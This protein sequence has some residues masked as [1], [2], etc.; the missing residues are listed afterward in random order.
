MRSLRILM[1]TTFY[2][3]YSFGGDAVGV[4][5][6]ARALAARGHRVAV[7]HDEDAYLN[8]GGRPPPAEAAAADDGVARIGLKARAGMVS[9]L[10]VQ[11]TGRPVL[12]AGRLREIV[13]A[14]PWDILWYNNMSL[15]GGP[16][17][18][19]YGDGLRVYEAHEHWLVC[20]THVLWR[21]GRELC[22]ARHCLSCVLSYRRPPQLWRATG[23]LDRHLDQVDLIVA[24]SAFSRD[25]HAEFGL[26]QPMEVLPYFLPPLPGPPPA[27]FAGHPRPYFLFVGRL[28]KIKGLQEVFPAM[29][30]IEGADL[31]VL[32]DGDYAGELKR[33]AAGNERI[34]FLGRKS[35][36]ELDAYYRGALGL[37][38]PSICYETFGIILIESFR[39]GT[40][41]IARRLGPFPEIVEAAGG[42]ELFA[43]EDELVAAMRRLQAEPELHA[44][45]AR[46]ALS[47]FAA[48]W[49]EAP[50]LCAWGAALARAAR[51]GGREELARALDA[52]AFETGAGA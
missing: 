29:D 45:M 13:R 52:G 36:E 20:P 28:E 42:G 26:R 25:K 5:R 1:F 7:V 35:P 27:P 37:V 34:R 3:P 4:Q 50:V 33:L 48:R 51:R 17:L 41:V 10:L 14:E 21:H 47:S 40:P 2:P 16:G 49:S 11:Q 6:M 44:T 18:I 8:L 9:D 32:G 43:T 31:L 46:A 22:D 15:V 24:K 30:S 19:A 23:L 39:L 12:H 38:V